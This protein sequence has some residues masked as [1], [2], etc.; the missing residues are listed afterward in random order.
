[1]SI[2]SFIIDSGGSGPNPYPGLVFDPNESNSIYHEDRENSGV[3]YRTINAKWTTGSEWM[4]VNAAAPAFSMA[5]DQA[6][7]VHFYTNLSA[8]G[9]RQTTWATWGQ[10][11]GNNNFFNAAD[12]GLSPTAS[13]PAINVTAL[14]NAVEAA[15]TAGGGTIFIPPGKYTIDGVITI[16]GA[17]VGIIIAGVSG[18]TELIQ[19]ATSSI[20]AV[21]KC[22]GG[23]GIRFQDMRLKYDQSV[24]SSETPAIAF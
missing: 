1:M 14:Q 4:V 17:D 7:N 21:S 15:K 16:S 3:L 23:Q 6:G 20:F 9:S 12:F 19:Q 11:S 8:G 13:V 18:A 10:G 22:K 5:Q 24:G 2:T